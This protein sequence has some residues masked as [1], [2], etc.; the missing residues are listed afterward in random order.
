MLTSIDKGQVVGLNRA[1]L[2][3]YL[4]TFAAILQM[5]VYHSIDEFQQVKGAVE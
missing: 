2:H 5:K 3:T 4:D 1:A